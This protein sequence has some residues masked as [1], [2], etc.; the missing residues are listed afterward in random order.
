MKKPNQHVPDLDPGQIERALPRGAETIMRR[1]RNAGGYACLVGGSLRDLL[2]ARPVSDWDIA[3]DL[4]PEQ[5][6]PLFH[7]VH[8]IGARFGTLLIPIGSQLYEVTTFRTEAGYRDGR[9]PDQVAY[10]RDLR[11]DLQRRDFTVNAMAWAPG[12]ARITDPFGGL[13][14]LRRRQI[15]AVGDP[16]QRFA[17]DA[18]RLLRAVRQ[19]TELGFQIDP[20]TFAAIREAAPGLRRISAE[21]IRDEL[22]RILRA[23]QPSPGFLLL[24]EAGLLADVLPEL[25]ACYGVAQNRFH[26]F[27]VF[28]HSIYAADAAPRENLIVR[29]AALLHDIGKP[30]TA[31]ERNGER[32]FYSHQLLGA[33]QARR[34]LRR[35]RYSREEI[36][37]VTHLVR[38][39]MFYYQTEWTDSAVRRFVRTVGL[40][41]IPDL[42]AVRLADMAGNGRRSGDRTPL[43]NLLQ[44]VDEVMT[45]DAALTVKDLAIGGKE[46]MGLGLAPGPGFGRI[47]RALL[48]EVLDDPAVNTAATL[49]ARAGELIAE[50]I[51]LRPDP[52]KHHDDD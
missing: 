7:R 18:L 48:E 43:Q 23:P 47:L 2:L 20:Q 16:A 13:A 32:T 51:H 1:I 19:A 35:L 15:R 44:R 5:I 4:T 22:N 39:H 25:D 29:M 46:L 12:E 27:D 40:D 30:Q 8:E 37:R 3:T 10:T 50:G 28:R 11:E 45:R 17:E 31:A 38:H 26:A 14:D 34:L 33:R 36:D 41:N 49:A 24:H 42:I 21:R 6:K 52:R 9:H